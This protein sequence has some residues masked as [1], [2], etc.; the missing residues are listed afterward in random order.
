MTPLILGSIVSGASSLAGGI[1]DAIQQKKQKSKL[2]AYQSDLNDWYKEEMATDYLDT[3][4]AKST[5][6]LLRKN[7][8]SELENL[9]NNLIKSG[10]TDE[11][12]VAYAASLNNNYAEKVATLAGMDT[13]YKESIRDD[14]WKN[15]MNLLDRIDK[16][17]VNDFGSKISPIG[18]NIGDYI[19]SQYK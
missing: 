2:E 14:Y 17:T 8:K 5:L 4:Q 7:N 10:N 15:S 9:D 1:V 13:E 3:S 11:A 16:V 12:K 18:E 19:M 6:S